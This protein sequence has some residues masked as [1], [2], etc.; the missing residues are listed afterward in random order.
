MRPL[1]HKVVAVVAEIRHALHS[2][3]GIFDV[4][5]LFE[6]EGVGGDRNFGV[7]D[8]EHSF[9]SGTYQLYRLAVVGESDTSL[10]LLVGLIFLVL[11]DLGEERRVLI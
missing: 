8:F 7:T 10:C 4:A 2:N 3:D 11:F 5:E 9:R 1:N 6:A